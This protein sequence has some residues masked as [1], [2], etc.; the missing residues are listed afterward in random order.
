MDRIEPLAGRSALVALVVGV[1]LAG[2]GPASAGGGRSGT[3]DQPSGPS[4]P[5]VI[6]VQV[7][8]IYVVGK[9]LRS[10]GQSQ[11]MTRDTFNAGLAYQDEQDVYHTHLGEALPQLNTDTWRVNSDGTMETTYRL[12]P[13]LTWH[14]GAVFSAEDFVFAFRVYATPEMGTANS[15]PINLIDSVQAP[16][17]RTVVIRWKRAWPDAYAITTARLPALPRHI[18]EE[19]FLRGDAEAFAALPYWTREF[20]GA[21]PY[22]MAHWE[23]GAYIDAEAFPGYVFGRP[24][25]DRLHFVF[26]PDQNTALANFLAD[27]I[28]IIFDNI[29]RYQTTSILEREWQRNNG[30][31]VLNRL[32]GIRRSEVQMRTEYAKP[33]TLQDVRMRRAIAHAT[34]REGLNQ[35]LID[36]QGAAAHTLIFPH[37]DFFPE[38]DRVISKYEYDVRRAEQLLNEIGYTKGPDGVFSSPTLGRLAFELWGLSGTQNESE[39]SIHADMLR[40]AGFDIAEYIVPAALLQDA[41]VRATFSGV[42]STSAGTVEG[43]H[44]RNIP[45]QQNRW[46]GGQRSGWVNAEFDRLIEIWDSTLD[47][48]ERNRLMVQAARIYSEETPS[49]PLYYNVEVLAHVAALSGVRAPMAAY[50]MHEWQFR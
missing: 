47:R 6:A 1:I 14:D 45:T 32:S 18:L 19:H 23:P 4:R 44:T 24:K 41:S 5:L 31:K 16:D 33:L 9:A 40:R 2:C 3:S 48:S 8:P 46:Q 42:H 7:E 21:G 28:H 20:V 34:D 12:K 25:I 50:N 38:V 29:M 30:G 37:V 43:M 11:G 13:N 26:I 15:L 35:G 17:P 22:K 27:A 49:I 39:I 36:G 10:S